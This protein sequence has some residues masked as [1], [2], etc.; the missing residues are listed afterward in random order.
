MNMKSFVYSYRSR[1]FSFFVA[2][3]VMNICL[4]NHSKY[5]SARKG[6]VTKQIAAGELLLSDQGLLEN[7]Q[8][9]HIRLMRGT[10][11]LN[12]RSEVVIDTLF[13]QVHIP[14]GQAWLVIEKD[15]L[16]VKSI[17]SF[18]QIQTKSGQ[19]L[20]LNRGFESWVGLVNS[21]GRNE[22]G[23]PQAIDF[24]QYLQF[25]AKYYRGPKKKFISE[26]NQLR[27]ELSLATVESSEIYQ[28]SINRQIAS[29]EEEKIIQAQLEKEKQSRIQKKKSEI[30][31]KTFSR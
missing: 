14:E 22:V 7:I 13:A 10:L 19:V 12:V 18:V 23:V 8:S 15:R 29:A 27:E 3:I 25:W 11:W 4:A 26:A 16:R 31:Q 9:E 5:L 30:Y 24:A 6:Q 2:L 20:E 17:S 21:Y 1:L 28:E